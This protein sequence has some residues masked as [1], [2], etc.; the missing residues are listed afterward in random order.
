MFVLSA[1]RQGSTSCTFCR[2][3]D[4]T[5]QV[6]QE[7]IVGSWRMELS[8]TIET[9]P[10]YVSLIRPYLIAHRHRCDLQIRFTRISRST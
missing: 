6:S 8:E 4:F 10:L 7:A 9:N 2:C 1:I 3:G 5:V